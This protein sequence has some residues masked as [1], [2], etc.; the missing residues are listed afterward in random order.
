MTVAA[1]DDVLASTICEALL[2]LPASLQLGSRSAEI[3]FLQLVFRLVRPRSYVALGVGDGSAFIAACCAARAQQTETICF[4]IDEWPDRPG[5][6]DGAAEYERLR[7]SLHELYPPALLMRGRAEEYVA[8]FGD[9]TLDVLHVAP[10]RGED[11]GVAG[12]A[13]A[14]IAPWL[15]KMS[16]AGVVLTAGSRVPDELAS[17]SLARIEVGGASRLTA[18]AGDDV[19]PA[20]AYL[21]WACARD[22]GYLAL[23]RAIADQAALLIPERGRARENDAAARA[24]D[25]L[26]DEVRVEARDELERLCERVAA[27]RYRGALTVDEVFRVFLLREPVA[28]ESEYWGNRVAGSAFADVVRWFEALPEFSNAS[29]VRRLRTFAELHRLLDAFERGRSGAPD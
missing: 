17:R 28:V 14:A 22:A 29:D 26:R 20:F 13:V 27:D 8:Q 12:D 2:Q 23:V 6:E 4:G 7:R 5:H 16:S 11:D 9:G 10:P 15:A 3:P 18:L 25:E 24:L 1:G 21:A 19:A